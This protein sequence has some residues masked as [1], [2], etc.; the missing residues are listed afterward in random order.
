MDKAISNCAEAAESASG[1]GGG[2]SGERRDILIAPC[3]SADPHVVHVLVGIKIENVRHVIAAL[4]NAGQGAAGSGQSG[5]SFSDGRLGGHILVLQPSTGAPKETVNVLVGGNVEHMEKT[6]CNRS[7]A[8]EPA[9][10]DG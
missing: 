4:D 10:G 3:G 1:S 2:V 7:K 9:A 6:V 5:L 8:G